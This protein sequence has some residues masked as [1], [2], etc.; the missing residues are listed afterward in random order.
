VDVG[1]GHV[2]LVRR[3]QV[4]L[5][6]HRSAD[7]FPMGAAAQLLAAIVVG[8]L[9]TRRM[10]DFCTLVSECL[11]SSLREGLAADTSLHDLLTE[12]VPGA[13]VL[14][15]RS[16]EAVGGVSFNRLIDEEVVA[17]AGLVGTTWEPVPMTTAVDVDVLLCALES[18]AL[19]PPASVETMLQRGYGIS[20]DRSLSSARRS[21][22]ALDETGG[23]FAL[24]YPALDLTLVAA[25]PPSVWAG[26][27][28]D[29]LLA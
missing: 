13:R 10:L 9:E 4:T 18:D 24:R 19:L 27:R 25:A 17:P 8:R 6:S 5:A 12:A 21:I 2:L 29:R 23:V 14:L 15:R 22:V 16:L 28:P 3:S 11:P 7:L 1:D 26:Q 20:Q